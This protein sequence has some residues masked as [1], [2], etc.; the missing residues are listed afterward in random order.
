L[1]S[2]RRELTSITLANPPATIEIDQ[3]S[4]LNDAAQQLQA[5]LT[6]EHG[7]FAT[8]LAWS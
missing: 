6:A 7:L 8:A 5:Y 2:L 1:K 4:L 3:S